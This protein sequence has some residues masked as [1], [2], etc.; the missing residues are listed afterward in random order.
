MSVLQ[1]EQ[2][3][4]SKQIFDDNNTVPNPSLRQL[5]IENRRLRVIVAELLT[6]NECLR[7]MFQGY[8]PSPA[9]IWISKGG[10]VHESGA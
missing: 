4:C 1:H 10:S 9:G 6:K 3:I 8:L 5:E 7:S 2:M